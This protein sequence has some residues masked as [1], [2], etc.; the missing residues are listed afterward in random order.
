MQF[1][2]FRRLVFGA[3]AVALAVP[4]GAQQTS[5]T[6]RWIDFHSPKD[7]NIVAW[8]TRSLQVADWT[9]IREVGVVYDAALVVTT[10]RTKPESTPNDD[11]FTVW[12]ASLTSH[13][14][15]P[16]L[17]GVN[18]RWFD[19]ENFTSEGPAELTVLYDNCENCAA[20]TFFTSFHY[21]LAH[22]VWAARWMR[23]GQGALAWSATA[24]SNS[25][26]VWTQVYAVM[27]GAEDRAELCTWNHF[28]YGKQREP[29]N[30]IFCYDVDP[31]S[32]LDR[33]QEVTGKEAEETME[34][35][36]CR[37]QNAVQGLERG[38]DSAVCQQMLN[39]QP[40]RKPVITPPA[41]NQG[42]SA[43][44]GGRR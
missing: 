8:V 40:L 30:T 11:T 15:V 42:R 2:G 13:V 37:A 31:F 26:I 38:Q 24:P 10:N 27:T 22:H 12:S 3:A 14:V 23:G 41:N 9:A 1:D 32:G 7:Q 35:R 34:L 19:W 18:L 36:L 39:T 20:S 17:T 33:T 6:F 44:P 43:P 21:D 25:G 16:L 5:D 28:D 4:L 29:S